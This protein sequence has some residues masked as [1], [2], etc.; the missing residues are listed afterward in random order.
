MV[1]AAVAVLG[2]LGFPQASTEDLGV[3]VCPALLA[4]L[5]LLTLAVSL[6]LA[7]LATPRAPQ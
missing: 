6:L 2:F 1:G 4:A 3:A 7:A 5:A